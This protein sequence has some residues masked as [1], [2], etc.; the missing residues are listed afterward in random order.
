MAAENM[1]DDAPI[2]DS[3]SSFNEAAANGRGKRNGPPLAW[4]LTAVLQ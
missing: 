4:T 3:E 1:R 2:P